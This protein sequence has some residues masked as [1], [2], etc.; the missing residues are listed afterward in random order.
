MGIFIHTHE[1]HPEYAADTPLMFING[2]HDFRGR[3][4]RR[5]SDLMMFREPRERDPPHLT[6]RSAGTRCGCRGRRA[7]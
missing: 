4:N 5:L 1:K 6:R 3:F 7:P 2:N